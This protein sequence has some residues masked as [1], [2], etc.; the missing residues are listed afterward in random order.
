MAFG[1]VM[2]LHVDG[3]DIELAPLSRDVMG[4]FIAYGGMQHHSITRYLGRRTAP[5][6]QDEEEW[7]DRVRAETDSLLWG[8]WVVKDGSRQLI[9]TSGLHHIGGD[10]FRSATSGSMIFNQDYW[11]KGIAKHTHMARTWYAFYQLGLSIIR[12]G[13]I[14]T[15]VASRR[16]LQ[17]SGYYDVS[18]ERNAVFVDG[19]HRHMQ[20][21]EALNPQPTFWKAWWGGER[22]TAAAVKARQRSRIAMEWAQQNVKLL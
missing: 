20:N 3:L 6:L 4:E 5:V 11:R 7:F 18:L 19:E 16:A 9:G 14:S 2:Q 13:A 8:I 21:L 17:H 22:P 1:P 15:N 12:S 10:H